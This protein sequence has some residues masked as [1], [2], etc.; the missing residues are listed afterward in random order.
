MKKNT[1]KQIY[2]FWI[3]SSFGCF[4]ALGFSSTFAVT[5][6]NMNN[7]WYYVG[8]SIFPSL[9]QSFAI[10]T[11]W[12]KYFSAEQISQ[13]MITEFNVCKKVTLAGSDSQIFIPTKSSD[14]WLTFID[15]KPTNVAISECTPS[16]CTTPWGSIVNHGSDVVAYV[17]SSDALCLGETRTCN[18]G[19]LWGSYSSQTCT[20]TS[21]AGTPRWILTNGQSVTAYA[22]PTGTC[23]SQTRTCTNGILGGT[24]TNTSCAPAVNGKC[25]I[26]TWF[27]VTTW[28]GNYTNWTTSDDYDYYGYEKDYW[29]YFTYFTNTDLCSAGTVSTGGYNIGYTENYGSWTTTW[30]CK[31]INGWTSQSC[32][33][34]PSRYLFSELNNQSIYIYNSAAVDYYIWTKRNND[35]TYTYNGVTYTALDTRSTS[36]PAQTVCDAR[37]Y[38]GTP[39]AG[40]KGEYFDFSATN[41]WQYSSGVICGTL[42]QNTDWKN[43]YIEDKDICYFDIFT[44]ASSVAMDYIPHTKQGYFD[45]VLKK[46]VPL[47]DTGV[48]PGRYYY[49][50][51]NS[52]T[53]MPEYWSQE[54]AEPRFYRWGPHDPDQMY[55]TTT[56]WWL[57]PYSNMSS[58]W[59]Y[60]GNITMSGYVYVPSSCNLKGIGLFSDPRTVYR[61]GESVTD[62]TTTF[63]KNPYS[64]T[65]GYEACKV[66]TVTCTN[67]S[68]TIR[69]LWY[70]TY[71][72]QDMFGIPV[73][74]Y[75]NNLYRPLSGHR[76]IPARA[77]FTLSSYK[78]TAHVNEYWYNPTVL[79]RCKYTFSGFEGGDEELY[80]GFDFTKGEWKA[81][82][83]WIKNAINTWFSSYYPLINYGSSSCDLDNKSIYLLRRDWYWYEWTYNKMYCDDLCDDD[84]SLY[85][86]C[87]VPEEKDARDACVAWSPDNYFYTL[88]DPFKLTRWF[89]NTDYDGKVYWSENDYTLE[90]IWE[91]EKWI[92]DY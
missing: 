72:L 87:T 30:T 11:A 69:Y 8:I 73:A 55:N 50:Y 44:Y 62:A 53:A 21:C 66:W 3:L 76:M 35:G 71:K 65:G 56:T 81:T 13:N 75:I 80:Y 86:N 51:G 77:Y 63:F 16:S 1:I 25:G 29:S 54:T 57:D 19:T 20:P 17:S 12:A 34:K 9:K 49:Y 43:G 52:S 36:N 90:G 59:N 10:P 14:E 61:E 15:K 70:C 82:F 74:E 46:C 89:Y 22:T 64:M 47:I 23:T 6:I 85:N 37:R 27:V 88:T 39:N 83:K 68:Y 32:T 67:G 2:K 48:I 28:D 4:I 41:N 24:Y 92:Y 26:A 84:M 42:I 91:D 60:S 7:R 18:N 58:N 33:S 38:T 31:G 5:S 40:W 45:A 78:D 79:S